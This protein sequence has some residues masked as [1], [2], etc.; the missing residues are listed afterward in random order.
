[1]IK[2]QTHD[3]SVQNEYERLKK[4]R[5][6]GAVVTFVGTVRDFRDSENSADESDRN[7]EPFFLAHYPGMTEKVLEKIEQE[8]HARWRLIN[9]T[10]I[11][12]VG[13]LDIDEQIVFVGASSAHRKDAFAAAEYMIDILKTDAPFWKKEGTHWVTAKGS[14]QD[15]ANSWLNVDKSDQASH[16]RKDIKPNND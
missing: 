9:T 1:M 15:K 3:F 10:I 2:V 4:K 16:S 7:E 8:A 5:V 12:R 14:D 6:C 11:H 13:D